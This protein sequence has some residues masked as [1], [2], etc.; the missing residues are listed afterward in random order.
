MILRKA[1]AALAA[2]YILIAKP[3]PETLLIYLALAKL[4]S[5]ARLSRLVSLT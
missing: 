2:R 5:N 1:G 4:A 3:S